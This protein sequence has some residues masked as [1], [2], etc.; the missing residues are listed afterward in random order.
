MADSDESKCP[1]ELEY[2][3]VMIGLAIYAA[4]LGVVYAS[5]QL[6]LRRSWLS[7]SG[8][9]SSSDF[10]PR[11]SVVIIIPARNEA[12]NIKACLQ[13]ILDQNYP[14]ELMQII[15]VDD[16]SEDRTLEF[17]RSFDDSRLKVIA[18]EDR[19]LTDSLSPK[20]RNSKRLTS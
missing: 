2:L 9:K 3:R 15:L 4:I 12:A 5:I 1:L 8:W 20:K 16:H 13:S 11:T 7:L 19:Q 10:D 6:G 17:A 14:S 18:L